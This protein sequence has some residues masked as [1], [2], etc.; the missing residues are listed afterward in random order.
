MG[1]GLNASYQIAE[2]NTET[3]EKME[4]RLGS[5]TDPTHKTINNNRGGN[6]TI[7]FNDITGKEVGNCPSNPTPNNANGLGAVSFLSENKNYVGD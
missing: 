2:T 3:G 6:L 4:N 1:E 7:S 5:Y